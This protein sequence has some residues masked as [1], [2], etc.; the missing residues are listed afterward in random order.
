MTIWYDS[1]GD[2][3]T[4]VVLVKSDTIANLNC[5][6]IKLG[7]LT[8]GAVR[9]LKLKVEYSGPCPTH[10]LSFDIIFQLAGGGF[11]DS[12]ISQKNFAVPP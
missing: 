9:Q 2:P 7:G 3:D 6:E 8:A 10:D 5:H 1:D 11:A 12:E 4:P